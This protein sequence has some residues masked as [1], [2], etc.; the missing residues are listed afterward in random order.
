MKCRQRSG[1]PAR[2]QAH[3][4][5]CVIIGAFRPARPA[6]TEDP[7]CVHR[8]RRRLR[9]ARPPP[10]TGA[11][12]VLVLEDDVAVRTALARRLQTYGYRTAAAATLDEALAI[13]DGTAVEALILDVGLEGGRSGLELLGPLR[14]RAEVR[15]APVLIFTGAFLTD[16]QLALIHRHQAFLFRK[17][18][19][20]DALVR[21]LDTLTGRDQPH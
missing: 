8:I 21:F 14:Q 7:P 1:I 16:A 12:A 18:E 2:V 15:S 10:M 13:L 5:A 19:G 9:P 20:F 11:R 3:R 6:F 17:P 4:P